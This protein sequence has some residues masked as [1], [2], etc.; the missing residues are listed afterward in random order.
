M[1][2]NLNL[3]RFTLCMLHSGLI[4]NKL[5]LYELGSVDENIRNKQIL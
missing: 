5:I 3:F 4:I 2:F 1:R